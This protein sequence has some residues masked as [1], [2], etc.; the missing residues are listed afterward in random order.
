MLAG[1]SF[2]LGVAGILLLPRLLPV[3]LGGRGLWIYLL[4]FVQELLL[5]G[6][7]ALLISLRHA[8]A[9]ARFLR[10]WRHP[11]SYSLG[12]SSLAAVSYSLA[13]I[14]IAGLWIALLEGMGITVPMEASVFMPQSAAEY[15]LAFAVSGLLPA[16]SE[17]LMFRGLLLH[18]LRRRYGDRR[19]IWLSSLLFA[20]LHLSLQGFSLLLVIGLFL[21]ALTLRYESLW[22]A[23]LFHGLYNIAAI[24]LNGLQARPSPQMIWLCSGIMIACA[25][26]LFRREPARET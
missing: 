4:V 1:L 22:P 18:F 25:Y 14:L 2:A 7:P 9:K 17:E 10:L 15:L 23:V 13:G 24:L 16:F 26:L 19:A 8:D 6:L 3:R 21:A 20:L 5:I 11:G 12:L